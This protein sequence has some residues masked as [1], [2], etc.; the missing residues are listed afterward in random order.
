MFTRTPAR[1]YKK[2]LSSIADHVLNTDYA[3]RGAI[4]IRGAEITEQLKTAP[5]GTFPFTST[6]Y[7]NIGNP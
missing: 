5:E 3:V 4:P 7:L 2:V 1:G 6:A